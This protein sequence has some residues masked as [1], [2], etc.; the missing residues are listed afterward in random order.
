MQLVDIDQM[1]NFDDFPP[2]Y[3]NFH[4]ENLSDYGGSPEVFGGRVI[5]AHTN[6]NREFLHII[7]RSSND[8]L[9]NNQMK[10]KRPML[11]CDTVDGPFMTKWSLHFYPDG[12]PSNYMMPDIDWFPHQQMVPPEERFAS[13]Y[14]RLKEGYE[15]VEARMMTTVL[16]G[17]ADIDAAIATNME[18]FILCPRMKV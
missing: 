6:V 14:V 1:D 17:D 3:A 2:D 13:L 16:S 4:G 12:H 5:T 9:F 10:Q 8:N 15:M 7:V 18:R 11:T